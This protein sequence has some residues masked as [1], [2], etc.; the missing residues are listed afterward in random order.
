MQAGGVA[1]ARCRELADLETQLSK[2]MARIVETDSPASVTAY[3]RKIAKIEHR[4]LV[5]AEKLVA[6]PRPRHSFDELFERALGLLS[7]LW[8]LWASGNFDL[9]RL[10]FAKCI[11]LLPWR[12]AFTRNIYVAIQY[13]KGNRYA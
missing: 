7:N 9:R 8:Q 10:A 4:K 2:L 6:G 13:F 5:V 11:P 12:G 3:E 1:E